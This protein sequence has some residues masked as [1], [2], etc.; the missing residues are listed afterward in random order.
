MACGLSQ[1]QMVYELRL[2]P[3]IACSSAHGPFHLVLCCGVF[4]ENDEQWAQAMRGLDMP[5][6]AYF[7]G[8]PPSV[9]VQADHPTPISSNLFCLGEAGMHTIQR[10]CIT[11]ASRAMGSTGNTTCFQA[12]S[13]M[14][15]A[16][17]FL[18]ESEKQQL[19]NLANVPGY[20]GCDV[21]LTQQFPKDV[22]QFVSERYGIW[23]FRSISHQPACDNVTYAVCMQ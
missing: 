19:M 14:Y 8:T 7:L 18:L 11:F 15:S 23:M 2:N 4:A 6:P 5:I 12:P 10:L 20:M 1:H 21:L 3:T 9:Q 22:H 16:C 17:V 13:G